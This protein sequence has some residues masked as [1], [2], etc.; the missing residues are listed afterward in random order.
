[1]EFLLAFLAELFGVLLQ[2]F[3]EFLLQA[4]LEIIME[5]GIRAVVER[6]R[7]RSISPWLAAMAY[8]GAG[9]GMGCVSLLILPKLMITSPAWRVASL[10]LI[11][12]AAGLAMSVLGDWRRRRGQSLLR[13]D[14]F[15][16]GWLFALAMA[17]VRFR[18]GG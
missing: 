17:L 2:L 6:M 9:G 1:M 13:I 15:A 18:F 7:G 5:V 3:G 4:L 8:C 16:W 10:V 12:I 14:R 11:P